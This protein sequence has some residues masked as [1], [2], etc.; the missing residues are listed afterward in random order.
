MPM[1]YVVESPPASSASS[2][3]QALAAALVVPSAAVG[4]HP[5]STAALQDESLSQRVLELEE[6][7]DR[8]KREARHY[9]T[10]RPSPVAPP[11]LALGNVSVA[12]L[13]ALA[14]AMAGLEQ[15]FESQ[16]RQNNQI[17]AELSEWRRALGRAAPPTPARPE[18]PTATTESPAVATPRTTG[19]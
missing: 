12:M 9:R 6:Q 7:V 16:R 18:P 13:A 10:L 5:P 11:T 1:P 3:W 4:D 2:V 19:H 15:R 8:L 17:L 14:T